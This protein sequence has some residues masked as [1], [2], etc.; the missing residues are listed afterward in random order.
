MQ[1][2][3]ISIITVTYNAEA[4]IARTISSVKNQSSESFEYII[5]D[6]GSTDTTMAIVNTYGDTIAKKISEQDRGIY[7]AMNKGLA[8]AQGEWVMF[9]NAGDVL[10]SDAII[11]DIIAALDNSIDFLYGDVIC[12]Y[13]T[14]K[15]PFF[16]PNE[17]KLPEA[18]KK[19]MCIFHNCIVFKT[20]LHKQFLYQIEYKIAADYDAILRM[21][22]AGIK[23]KKLS[24]TMVEIE[25]GRGVSYINQVASLQER[26]RIM[27]Q[28]QLAWFYRINNFNL[29]YITKFKQLIKNLLPKSIIEIIVRFK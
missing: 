12:D 11:A 15:K 23:V 17:K 28:H 3:I 13:G 2:I 9:L 5:I 1:D 26:Q 20:A 7:D 14:F 21:V 27:H 10:A 18:I 25:T 8:M 16:S 24:K 4:D 22:L 6:G 29:L 19:G